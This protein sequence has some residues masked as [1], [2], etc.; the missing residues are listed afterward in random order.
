MTLTLSPETQRMVEEKLKDGT[1]SSF[2]G[3]VHAGLSASNQLHSERLDE[4]T[5]DAIDE[6]EDQIE[7]GQVHDL[8]DVKDQ[9]RQMFNRK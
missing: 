1:F 7:R 8:K 4:E 2:D 9:I 6:A 3:I 5:L